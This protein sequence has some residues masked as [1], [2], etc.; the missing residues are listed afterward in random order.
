[1]SKTVIIIEKGTYNDC[2]CGCGLQVTRPYNKYINGHNKKYTSK[3]PYKYKKQENYYVVYKPEHPYANSRGYVYEHRLVY[4][5]YNKC[6]L[7]KDVVIH[8]INGIKD[9]N[10]IENLEPKWKGDHIADHCTLD[11]TNRFCFICGS[12]NTTLSRKEKKYDLRK[13]W[14]KLGEKHNICHKCYCRINSKK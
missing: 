13:R 14:Y 2:A 4:E 10:R 8:H 12:T 3:T 1:V 11:M 6:C 5:E 7:L 9:D